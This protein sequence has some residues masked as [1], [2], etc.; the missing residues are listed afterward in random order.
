[1]YEHGGWFTRMRYSAFGQYLSLG[2]QLWKLFVHQLLS[3]QYVCDY[4]YS[5]DVTLTPLMMAKSLFDCLRHG[6]Q[7][8]VRGNGLSR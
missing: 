5:L 2:F 6:D 3:V 1:M 7:D 8:C 4:R